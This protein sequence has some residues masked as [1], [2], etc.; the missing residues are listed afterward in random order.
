V[1]EIMKLN[2]VST[3]VYFRCEISYVFLQKCYLSFYL[4]CSFWNF[5]PSGNGFR[6]CFPGIKQPGRGVHHH[7]FLEPRLNKVQLYVPQLM[8]RDTALS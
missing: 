8:V 2:C 6:I 7:T 3:Y 4:S 5:P 1:R